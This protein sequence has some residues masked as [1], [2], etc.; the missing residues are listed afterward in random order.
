MLNR[1]VGNLEYF[2]VKRAFYKTKKLLFLE[3]KTKIDRLD[4]W[5][6][7]HLPYLLVYN[8]IGKTTAPIFS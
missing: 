8:G 2:L 5:S 4:L 3:I 7:L 6:S 1:L